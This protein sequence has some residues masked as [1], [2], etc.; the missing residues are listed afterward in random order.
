[1]R[2]DNNQLLRNSS[3]LNELIKEIQNEKDGSTPK[4]WGNWS[5]WKN[6]QN[7][8]NWDNWSNWINWWN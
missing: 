8:S 6:W 7:W 1:M 4:A 5:N 2:K 3:I